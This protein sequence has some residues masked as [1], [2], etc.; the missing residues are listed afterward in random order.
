MKTLFEDNR[1]ILNPEGDAFYKESHSFMNELFEK[2][3]EFPTR[4][5]ESVLHSL[6][7][8]VANNA[9]GDVFYNQDQML[10][11]ERAKAER[12]AKAKEQGGEANNCC[13]C[14]GCGPSATPTSDDD[15]EEDYEN[16]IVPVKPDDGVP[17]VE[18]HKYSTILDYDD[19]EMFRRIAG[20]ITSDTVVAPTKSGKVI[21][22]FSGDHEF[23][24][25][26]F[27]CLQSSLCFYDDD[28]CGNCSH[29]VN[30]KTV[31]HAYQANKTFDKDA[32]QLIIDAPDARTAVSLGR[33]SPIIPDWDNRK[34]IIMERILEDKFQNFEMK[35]RLLETGDAE[36]VM[37]NSKDK[38]W[39]VNR[40]GDGE[41]NLGKLLMQL[42]D[43]IVK[44]EGTLEEIVS[45]KLKREGL[46][47][48]VPW[49]SF[50]V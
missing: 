40:Q 4:E 9:R 21:S 11:F 8:E 12:E 44:D 13:G 18:T 28:Q 1:E 43:K 2:W 26:D 3:E 38:Y 7:S 5:I 33:K 20:G 23:L 46:G 42:R 30:F 14:S 6:V 41:N 31:E 45:A 10:K 34:N 19:A 35:V 37:G 24:R 29:F 27:L 25:N 22:D 50:P 32:Q 16:D 48:V 17:I 49:I 47:F 39:G 36:L 15:D